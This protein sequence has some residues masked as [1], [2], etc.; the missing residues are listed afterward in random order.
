M[1]DYTSTGKFLTDDQLDTLKLE[2]S[3]GTITIG[4]VRAANPKE[5]LNRFA[6]GLGLPD[7][8]GNYGANLQTGEVLAP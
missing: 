3:V 7:I 2:L 5:T 1:S 8:P 4:G 6:L